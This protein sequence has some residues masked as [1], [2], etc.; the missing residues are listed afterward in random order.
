MDH[1]RPLGGMVLLLHSAVEDQDGRGIVWHPVVRP[2]CEV[3]LGHLQRTF[4]AAR[5]LWGEIYTS[6][7]LKIHTAF[8][9]CDSEGTYDVVSKRLLVADGYLEGPKAPVSRLRPIFLALDLAPL[10]H[11]GDH[12][13][14]GRPFLPH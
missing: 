13:D 4:L 12:D 11:V 6:L 3:E 1:H 5:Q 9:Y 14:G 2:G 10:L 8:S 7:P